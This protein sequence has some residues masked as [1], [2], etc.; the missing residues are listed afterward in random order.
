MR[1]KIKYDDLTAE[2]QTALSKQVW[3][4]GESRKSVRKVSLAGERHIKD[5]MPKDTGR[6]AASWGHWTPGMISNNKDA[7]AADAEWQESDGGLTITQGSNVEYIGPLN[8]G[9]SQQ[10]PAG[11]LDMAEERAQQELDREI[12]RIMEGL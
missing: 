11:F 4:V 10:A 1:I 2:E 6:A 7:S 12:D 8:D 5:I 9:H 3:A